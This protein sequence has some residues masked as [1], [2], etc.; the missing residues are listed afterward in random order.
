MNLAQIVV[1]CAQQVTVTVLSHYI[2][3]WF[4]CSKSSPEYLP[5]SSP[6][7]TQEVSS[8]AGRP[9]D[10]V[11][12][13]IISLTNLARSSHPPPPTPTTINSLLGPGTA[14]INLWI[15]QPLYCSMA[16]PTSPWLSLKV[17]FMK[18][19]KKVSFYYVYTSHVHQTF[20]QVM[21]RKLI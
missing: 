1:S 21:D 20:F 2:W 16:D 11:L 7:S 5:W 15:L 14:L 10:S 18:P 12:T 3:D 17:T 9:K 6:Q 8:L 4:L 13:L 19:L